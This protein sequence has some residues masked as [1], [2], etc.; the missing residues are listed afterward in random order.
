MDSRVKELFERYQ[1]G[2]ASKEE[3]KLVEDWFASFDSE[4]QSYL[5]E[6]DRSFIF[7]SM[8]EEI[9]HMLPKK[10]TKLW[11]YKG[12]MQ[13]AAILLA[14]TCLFL[15]KTFKDAT[16]AD[17]PLTY[18]RITAPY[19]VKKQFQLPDG[20]LVYLNSG[21]QVLISSD[22]NV[23]GRNVKL[24]GEAYFLVKHNAKKPFAI[25]TDN[26][27]IA[28][29][30]TSFNVKAYPEEGQIK[31]A[32]E[33]G[34]VK[35]EKS[36]FKL[37]PDTYVNSL[38]P[39]QQFVFDK[40]SLRHTLNHIESND[41]SAWKQNKLRFE[42]ASFQDIAFQL[43]RWYNVS[44][45]LKNTAGKNRRYTVSFNNEPVNNVLKVLRDLSGISYEISNNNIVI[46]LKNCK[47]A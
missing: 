34:I 2:K 20:T 17:K 21:S 16:N 35:I 25:H 13:V 32:V 22:Y 10:E 45:S 11:P 29:I 46:N 23:K 36:N 38:T 9:Q 41:I 24:M 26:L 43:Q 1:S 30:G 39:N 19:G 15:F 14:G 27:I 44:V 8:D 47:K 37:K 33:S 4:Q 31:V 12:W 3:I 28:D 6:K 7:N 40:A 42:S 18:T 5:S